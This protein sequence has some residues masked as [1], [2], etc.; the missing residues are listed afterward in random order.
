MKKSETRSLLQGVLVIAAL[1]I[2]AIPLSNLMVADAPISTDMQTA[3]TELEASDSGEAS[4]AV[5]SLMAG[6]AVGADRG[7]NFMLRNPA[8]AFVPF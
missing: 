8:S 1:A 5:S 7:A 3:A 2:V 4:S 6:S